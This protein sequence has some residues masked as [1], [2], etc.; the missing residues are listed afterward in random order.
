MPQQQNQT[1]PSVTYRDFYSN[2]TYQP[3]HYPNP[4]VNSSGDTF[5]ANYYVNPY[6][7]HAG[8]YPNLLQPLHSVGFLAAKSVAPLSTSSSSGSSTCSNNLVKS[9]LSPP[10]SPSSS[11]SSDESLTSHLSPSN[12]S[13]QSKSAKSKT[14]KPPFSYIA[15]IVMAIQ[16]SEAKKMTLNEIYQYLSTHFSF[17]QGQ[18]QGWKN[19]V[20]HNLSLNECF[21]KLPKAMGKPGK[22]HYWTIDPNCEF[23]FEEGSFRR[24]PR[25]F[26][27]K[28]QTGQNG[29]LIIEGEADE[30]AASTP[31]ATPVPTNSGLNNS[32][33]STNANVQVS[34]SM[35]NSN[36]YYHLL[37]IESN[38]NNSTALNKASN[39]SSTS[40]LQGFYAPNAVAT[41]ADLANS[42][43][44]ASYT[45]NGSSSNSTG[46]SSYAYPTQNHLHNHHNPHHSAAVL[47]AV[48]QFHSQF[49]QSNNNSF[50]NSF[51]NAFY[52]NSAQSATDSTTFG[53][54]SHSMNSSQN[55]KL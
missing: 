2:P 23:M 27:R 55:S 20:R 35:T 45:Q 16:N 31:I 37:S 24:R 43:G 13:G 4:Y 21:I 52:A 53:H 36:P 29:S 25:G 19:S 54:I 6:D 3:T 10:T 48:N 17:F 30:S 49:N 47:T 15:L 7:Q 38:N 42:S 9:Q 18:Y 51:S 50:S 33:T 14:E 11:V 28:C 39:E 44:Y 8:T 1:K 22:G 32:S 41:F 40:S 46:P 12:D 34:S 5:S 26:R